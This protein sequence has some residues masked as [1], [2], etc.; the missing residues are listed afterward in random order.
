LVRLSLNVSTAYPL[1][2]ILRYNGF[3][4]QKGVNCEADEYPPAAFWQGAISP[5]QYIRFSPGAQNGG[6][7]SLFNL[8][9]CGY[10]DQGN[11]PVEKV[12]ERYVSDRV[13]GNMKR[14]V[15][16]Y[17][18]RTTR[19]ALEINFQ[20]VV[21]PDGKA[22]LSV[23]PCWPEVLLEDPGFAL[24]TDDPYYAG[25]RNAQR[26]GKANY[27]GLIPVDVLGNHKPQQGYRKRDEKSHELDPEAW[28]WDD[29]NSTRRVTEDELA[30][31]LG[32]LRCSS[33][34]CHK[35]MQELGIESARIVQDPETSPGPAV[36]SASASRT[37]LVPHIT[38]TEVSGNASAGSGA[39]RSLPTPTQT[40][41]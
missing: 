31:D 40:G 2:H 13:V 12:N 25:D 23:N 1:A 30:R 38:A 20:N 9:F 6:A 33:A 28:V 3:M 29:G 17:T 21:D 34:D 27:P 18:A 26:Y 8:R 22:G 24:L 41:R 39:S 11:L 5:K 14:K 32:I 36:P 4:Q 19:R 7:G 35:E 37:Q 16:Q 10:D 15:T